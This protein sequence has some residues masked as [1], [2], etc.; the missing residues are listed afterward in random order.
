MGEGTKVVATGAGVEEE[1]R[2]M[3]REE[4]CAEG[5][6]EDGEEGEE[7]ERGG[8]ETGAGE[9]VEGYAEDGEGDGEG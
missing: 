2:E 1:K 6:V 4:G 3:E 7:G 5:G 9:R 8:E